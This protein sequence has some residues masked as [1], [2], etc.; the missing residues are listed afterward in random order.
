MSLAR[1]DVC[2]IN[3]FLDLRSPSPS[4]DLF[5]A[6]WLSMSCQRWLSVR[7]DSFGA[8]L[9][10]AVGLLAVFTRFTLSPGETGVAL[11]YI[12]TAQST[13]S[14]MI[15]QSA[16]I[17]NNMNAVE[18]LLH[19]ANEVPQEPPHHIK[20]TDEKL[21]KDW[22]VN[23]EI[24]F[25]KVVASHRPGLPSVLKGI[26]INIKAGEHVAVCGRTG[27]GKSTRKSRKGSMHSR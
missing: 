8:L 6:Y 19:Y 17:E 14:W 10:L 13:F 12:L 7:L 21:V 24:K 26:D 5:S 18:R 20:E 11:S 22:P 16:E 2:A 3:L 9:V 25:E 1:D 23:G 4:S 15:R 27:A